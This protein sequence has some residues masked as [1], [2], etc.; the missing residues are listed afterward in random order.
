MSNSTPQAIR[1]ANESIRPT[2]DRLAQVYNFCRV[3]L[4]RNEAEDWIGVF[5]A[6]DQKIPLD[7]GSALD[8]RSPITPEA[9]KLMVNAMQTFV[10]S[11]EAN[12]DELRKLVFQIAVNP[13]R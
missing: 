7:D 6:L 13:D 12:V 2:A 4:A 9:V 3:Q 11:F 1:I 10:D 5:A 8:G